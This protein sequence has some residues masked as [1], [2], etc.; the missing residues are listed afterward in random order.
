MSILLSLFVSSGNAGARIVHSGLPFLGA[1]D[2]IARRIC[3][4]R[5]VNRFCEIS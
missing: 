1:C 4:A 3:L 5:F 2:R